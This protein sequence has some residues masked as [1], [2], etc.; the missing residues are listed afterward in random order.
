MTTYVGSA[1]QL[2]WITRWIADVHEAGAKTWIS[3]PT[4]VLQFG[5]RPV[6]GGAVEWFDV[7]V[8]D[9]GVKP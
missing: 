1:M 4:P 3:R 9:E 2:R 7:P 5:L 8:E 6:S